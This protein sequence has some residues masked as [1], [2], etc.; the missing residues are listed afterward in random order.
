MNPFDDIKRGVVIG[1]TV[2]LVV[3]VLISVAAFLMVAW[4]R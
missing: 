4:L 1:L 3:S 2:G